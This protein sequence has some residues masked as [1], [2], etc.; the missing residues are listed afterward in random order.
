MITTLLFI[1]KIIGS[2]ALLYGYYFL[3]LR[4]KRFHHYNRFFLLLISITSVLLPFIKIPV[5]WLGF[6]TQHPTL[7][8]TLRVVSINNWEEPVTVYASKSIWNNLF[9]AQN[10][11]YALYTAGCITGLIILARS[12]HYIR[13]LKKKYPFEIF[14]NTCFF[15]TSEKGTPFSFFRNIFWNEKI[16]LTSDEGQQIFRHELFHVNQQHSTDI[17]LMELLCIIGWF[18]PF[19]HLVKKELRAIHEFLADEYAASSSNKYEY[20]E[21]LLTY[22]IRQKTAPLTHPFFHHQIKRRIAMIT[23]LDQLRRSSGY[24]SRAM[25]LPLLF[26]IFCAFAVKLTRQNV[27]VHN[28]VPDKLITIVVDAGHGGIDAGARSQNGM[29]EKDIT[30]AITQKMYELAPQYNIKVVLTRNS[31]ILPGNASDIRAGLLKRVEI[32]EQTKPDAFISV[33]VNSN[34]ANSTSTGFDAWISGRKEDQQSKKLASVILGSLKNLYTVSDDIH[35]SPKG[36]YVLDKSSCPAV[37]IECGYIDNPTDA[38]FISSKENQ[39]KIAKN[40]LEAIVQYKNHQFAIAARNY[41]NSFPSNIDTEPVLHSSFQKDKDK[42]ISEMRIVNKGE[43]AVVKFT[44][45]DSSII[46]LEK[47]NYSTQNQNKDKG[48]Y[49]MGAIRVEEKDSIGVI[50]FNNNDSAFFR[51]EK[52]FYKPQDQSQ[53]PKQTKK[54]KDIIYSK[55]E[56]EPEYPGGQSGWIKYLVHNLKYPKAAITKEIQGTVVVQ[57]VVDKDGKVSDVKALDGPKELQEE[58]IRII[59]EGGNWLAGVQ[60]GKKVKVYKKQPIIYRLS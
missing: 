59:K 15:Q 20:A 60:N 36:I 26:V 18:N 45:G 9:T 43:I 5:H 14:N 27:I 50:K 51:L 30:L 31:D 44:N 57:F 33:H 42:Y 34:E 39:D 58:S 2:S 13:R 6:N 38:A 1:T 16:S 53:D 19:F 11:C 8:S 10:G 46:K 32:E 40:I 28:S 22:A 47:I 25:V 21:L 29:S 35:Q 41:Q 54:V 24:I 37:I 3:F 48:V 7:I 56:I 17:L 12:L 49:N 55:V 4:N 23:K 52:D